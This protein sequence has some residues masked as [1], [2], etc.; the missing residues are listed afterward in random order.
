MTD[1][2]CPSV[3]R[4]ELARTIWVIKYLMAL[5]IE[6]GY[7]DGSRGR[8]THLAPLLYHVLRCAEIWWVIEVFPRRALEIRFV[9]GLGGAGEGFLQA[10]WVYL[11]DTARLAD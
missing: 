11:I 3:S 4:F 8:F 7:L 9:D 6:V 1:V 5:T 10:Q 2:T